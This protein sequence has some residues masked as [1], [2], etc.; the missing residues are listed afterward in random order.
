MIYKKKVRMGKWRN[1][2]EGIN[3]WRTKEKEKEY[4]N[5]G[6]KNR[7]KKSNGLK[8]KGNKMKI[9]KVGIKYATEEGNKQRKDNIKKEKR[10][11]TNGE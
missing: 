3:K 9:N 6:R 4:G 8:N 10:K 1:L 7:S 2:E 5:A 11:K